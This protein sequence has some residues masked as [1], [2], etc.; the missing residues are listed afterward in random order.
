[1]TTG[2]YRSMTLG[3]ARDRLRVLV[4]EG[5][6]CPCCTQYAKVYRRKI[7]SSM[8]HDLIV[9]WRA[10]GTDWGYL[11][12]L[13]SKR[14]LKGNREESKLRYWGLVREDP[15]RREDGGRAGWWRITPEGVLF[16]TDRIRVPKYARIY[17]A[18][19]LGLQGEPIGIRDA[20]G[21]RFD[22]QEL[23]NS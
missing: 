23:M 16:V 15:E 12:D 3:E 5:H 2:F 13:R 21:D 4:D 1:M 10:F 22:Y 18:R 6:E 9:M 11:P 8:A 17:D 14:S 7:N 19:C 20:L